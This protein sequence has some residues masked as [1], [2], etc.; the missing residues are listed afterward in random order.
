VAWDRVGVRAAY[1][2]PGVDAGTDR[3]VRNRIRDVCVIWRVAAKA[4]PMTQ[5]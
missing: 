1:T 5:I 4:P 2:R 3:H